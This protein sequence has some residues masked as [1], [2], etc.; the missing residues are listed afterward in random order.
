MRILA[1]CMCAAALAVSIPASGSSQTVH[2]RVIDAAS[3]APLTAASVE[4]LDS[5][6][7]VIGRS[8]VDPDG[9][10]TFRQT[11]AAI[12]S[13]RA[14]LLGYEDT[15]S[16]PFR[17]PI[18]SALVLQMI[19]DA[20][21]VDPL[22][23][24]AAARVRRL[25]TAGFYARR[26]KGIGS[27]ITREKIDSVAPTT[28]TDLFRSI[29]GVRVVQAGP[30]GV[31]FDVLMPGAATMFIRDGKQPCFPSVMIDGVVV[32][33]GGNTVEPGEWVYLAPPA[34][35]EAIEVYPR[36]SGLP[37]QVAGQTSPCGSIVIWMRRGG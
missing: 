14:T 25:V 1:P 36:S 8:G 11:G 37:P 6:G 35:I 12:L 5:A 22:E 29:P 15:Y 32:R 17:A 33:R 16:A 28:V 26:E 13:V 31:S 23:V 21:S 9:G 19:Q 18:D 34:D 7:T 2:G 10:F 30:D 27:F 4:L 24:R 3:G 20:V